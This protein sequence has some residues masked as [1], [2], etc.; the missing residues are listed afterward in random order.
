MEL[1]NW[2]SPTAL[3]KLQD[4]VKLDDFQIG[5]ALYLN[6]QLNLGYGDRLVGM[7]LDSLGRRAVL[8][9]NIPKNFRPLANKVLPNASKVVEQKVVVPT[10]FAR[11]KGER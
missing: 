11:L 2:G 4:W 10:L 9:I 3:I 7:F 5:G 1:Q 8:P 6:P